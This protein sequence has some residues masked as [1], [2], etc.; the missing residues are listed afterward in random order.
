MGYPQLDFALPVNHDP[1]LEAWPGKGVVPTI[2][3]WLLQND[4]NW[5][6]GRI[7]IDPRVFFRFNWRGFNP[8]TY[9]AGDSTR[10]SLVDPA[11][12]DLIV[13]PPYPG[14]PY[15]PVWAAIST[16]V[17]NRSPQLMTGATTGI[18][19]PPL[20]T[21]STAGYT[22]A[23]GLQLRAV[24]DFRRNAATSAAARDTSR[25][26]FEWDVYLVDTYPG[27]AQ[28]T[29]PTPTFPPGTPSAQMAP[30]YDFDGDGW[31]NFE[32]FAL[33]TD[34][35]NAASVPI[36][37]P[38]LNA[39]TDQII[40]DVPKRPYVGDRVLYQIQYSYDR[41]NWTT[42]QP[43]DPVYL[44]EFDNAERIRVRSRRPS[45]PENSYLRV[46]VSAN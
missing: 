18:E 35:S 32:E 29:Y 14:N 25:R 34:P 3:D 4:E 19:L 33:Q 16:P 31:T 46:R 40:L 42:I 28:Q 5:R 7:E 1:P 41:V 39:L 26:L 17:G 2:S 10:F 36:V 8:L 12:N 21:L 44:I 13:Y 30:G 45:P 15:D 22:F 23:P 43:G 6:N 9:R 20:N 38:Y 27:Y 11:W 37:E 24:L